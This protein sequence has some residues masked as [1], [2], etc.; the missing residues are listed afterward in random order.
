[1]GSSLSLGVHFANMY[2]AAVEERTFREHQKPRIY[3]RYIDD[4]FVMIK[5][6]DDARK[7][8]DAL[9]RNSVGNFTTEHS[10]QK[11]LPFLDVP[12]KQQEGQFK[13][14]VYTK[15]TSA[16]N[17]EAGVGLHQ[18]SALSPFLFVLVMG[19]LSEEIR[20]EELWE[21]YADELVITAGNEEDV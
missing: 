14:I 20:D 1:M 13:M 12:E 5:E 4:I 7:L 18:G 3:G 8:A 21:L 11:T 10:Q 19:V 17:F 2:M 9:K 16:E 6:P 15:A